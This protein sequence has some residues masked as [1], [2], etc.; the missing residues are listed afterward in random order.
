MHIYIYIYIYIHK[1]IS[2]FL[3]E[4]NL[5]KAIILQLKINKFKK[6]NMEPIR[7]EQGP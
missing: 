3:T 5:Y 1:Y 7:K 2:I 6:S 4:N